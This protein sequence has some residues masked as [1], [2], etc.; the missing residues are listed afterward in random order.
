MPDPKKQ[1]I[2]ATEMSGLLGVSPYIT[3]WMLYQRFAKGIEAPGPDH[4]RL[5][6]GTKME[7]LLLEQAA[8]DLK[9][10]VKTNR[11]ADGSQIYL[12][13]GLLGCSRD[14]DIYDP[15]RGP[16][17]LETKCCFDYKILMQEWDGGKTPPRQHEIQVQQ[18][19]YVGDGE[20]SYEWG[21]IALWCGGDMT[22]FHR[23]PMPDLWAKFEEEA[24]QFF[25]DVIAGREPEPFGSP[26]EVPLLKQLFTRETGEIINAVEI[27][28]EVEATKLAQ[29]VVDAEYQRVQRLAAEKVEEQTKAKLLGLLKEADEIELPQGIRVTRTVQTRNNKAKPASQSTAIVVKAHIPQQ[30]DGGFGGI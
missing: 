29:Q 25:D 12:R 27:M 19:M 18:Q 11:Q 24:K 6:W 20:K 3:K 30:I 17:A 7:P 5:D 21:T 10:E 22:Y 14:A 2:S 15:Q 26:V 13:R 28:G 9:L 23:K 16:G 1:T 8:A 4:N